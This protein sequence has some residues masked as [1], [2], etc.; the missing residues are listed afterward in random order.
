MIDDVVIIGRIFIPIVN[1][2]FY[3]TLSSAFLLTLYCI[4]LKILLALNTAISDEYSLVFIFN[5]CIGSDVSR[6][7]GSNTIKIFEFSFVLL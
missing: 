3:S 2:V 4:V 1:S 7:F 6:L 5:H